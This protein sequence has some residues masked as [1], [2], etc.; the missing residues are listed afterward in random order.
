MVTCLQSFQR[1]A[2]KS[3]HKAE[4]KILAKE[5]IEDVTIRATIR[6]LCM[7][8][9]GTLSDKQWQWVNRMQSH[10]EDY[11]QSDPKVGRA[12]SEAASTVLKLTGMGGSE[13]SIRELFCR[14]SSI[15]KCYLFAPV[16][17]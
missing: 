12:I 8:K 4:C 1:K 15:E 5:Q 3:H 11:Y 14:V 7:R 9:L 17:T 13:E 10:M 6:L 16:L 2:W